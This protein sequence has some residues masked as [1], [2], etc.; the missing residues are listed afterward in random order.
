MHILLVGL[1]HKTAPLQVR[2][3]VSF[4]KEQLPDALSALKEE[5]G[6]SV[7]LSTC[8]RTEVYSTTEDPAGTARKITDFLA[9][10]HSLPREE[11]SSYLYE[12]TD[13]EAVRHLFRVA[14]GLDSM[15]VGESQI[16]GQV[17]EALTGA[18]EA[19]SVEMPLIGLFHAGVRMGRRA[20]EETDVGRN[21]LSV[22]Y[23]GVQLAQRVMGSLAGLRVLLI[24]AGEAGRLVA[25]A[26]RTVG[27]NDLTIAN[28][29]RERAEELA[30]SLGGAVTPFA[31]IDVSLREADIVIAATDSP[32]FVITA[33]MVA[34]TTQE[35]GDRLLFLFD[36]ALPRDIDPGAAS[37]ASVR[38]F[39][40]DDLSSIAEE[41]LEERR[42]A[43][44]DAER[45][46][47]EEL[48]RFMG[49]W[50]SLDA[51]PVI[52]TLRQQA[53]EIRRAEL[54]RAIDRMPGIPPEHLE[55]M[56]ALT[57]SIVNRLL[58][59][60]TEFLKRGADRSQIQAVRDL[61]RLWDDD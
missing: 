50:D 53:E 41:N 59:D 48:G 40:I 8:N 16:L 32:D 21:A 46:V 56:D 14:S 6:E 3:R 20:R 38:L 13:A 60:P 2:E 4:T 58:H 22:S 45:I 33:D 44:V 24:G 61:F 28:R 23:A 39:N 37:S 42:R 12:R 15:I 30:R 26:L 36:L 19:Q 9:G 7:I 31:E 51:A 43:A 52:K 49:W 29:T 47:E 1:N 57:R 11:V 5:V 18:S 27:V 10:F 35:R 54:E 34:R 25:S 17:R 55:V